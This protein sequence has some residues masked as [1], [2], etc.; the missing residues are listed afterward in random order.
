MR[1]FI[2]LAAVLSM[3]VF[4]GCGE[5]G[6]GGIT[7]GGGVPPVLTDFITAGS[8][9]NAENGI[10]KNSFNLSEK[11]YFGFT[12]TDIDLDSY[13]MFF[14]VKDGSTTV[15]SDSN[16]LEAQGNDVT[17]TYRGEYG[18]A[19]GTGTFTITM[20]VEDKKCNKSNSLSQII[21]VH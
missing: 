13:L 1:K 9:S 12:L 11:I 2:L 14:T 6:E 8:L 19:A 20:Y 3:F 10:A 4:A 17:A 7:C 5:D 18:R 16:E 15:D 21:V